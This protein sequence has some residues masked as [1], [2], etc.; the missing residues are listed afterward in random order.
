MPLPILSRDPERLRYQEQ[1]SLVLFCHDFSAGYAAVT[2]SLAHHPH[3]TP[4]HDPNNTSKRPLGLNIIFAVTDEEDLEPESKAA[5]SGLM[6][7]VQF[8]DAGLVHG[9]PGDD[10]GD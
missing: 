5:R 4:K 10:G 7:I 2:P 1:D 9:Q 8:V 6:L 3:N